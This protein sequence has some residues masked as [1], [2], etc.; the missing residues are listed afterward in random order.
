M[1]EIIHT[2]FRE[3]E[4]S[5]EESRKQTKERLSPSEPKSESLRVYA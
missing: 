3:N 5:A 2:D 4:R 1:Q